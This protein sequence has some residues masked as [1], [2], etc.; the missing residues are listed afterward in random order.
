MRTT[1]HIYQEYKL[2][3]GPNRVRLQEELVKQF[4]RQATAISVQR[5]H[6]T[7]RELVDRSVEK[8]IL[9]LHTFKGDSKLSTWFHELCLNECVN[10]HRKDKRESKNVSMEC[11]QP[12]EEEQIAMQPKLGFSVEGVIKAANL[13]AQEQEILRLKMEGHTNDEIGQQ[14]GQTKNQVDKFFY[15]VRLKVKKVLD[16][17]NKKR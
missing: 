5:F 4:R 9:K 1:D 10:W 6:I 3:V 8:G 11:L 14:I 15:N 7:R 12:N 2:A 17:G 16:K 13:D